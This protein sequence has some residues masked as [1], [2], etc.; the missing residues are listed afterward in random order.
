MCT[1]AWAV[2]LSDAEDASAAVAL[3]GSADTAVVALVGSADIAVVARQAISIVR[4]NRC[5]R[6][7]VRSTA[8][9]LAVAM[10][11]V[12]DFARGFRLD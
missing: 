6:F 1:A 8:L 5:S 2:A 10:L 11:V 3:V 4:R 12:V 9:A 7:M